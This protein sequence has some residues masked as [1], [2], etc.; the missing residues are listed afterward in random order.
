[1]WTILG[2]EPPKTF[3]WARNKGVK[4]LIANLQK[5]GDFIY[6]EDLVVLRNYIIVSFLFYTIVMARHLLTLMKFGLVAHCWLDFINT[7]SFHGRTFCDQRLRFI[8]YLSVR[9]N[10][11]YEKTFLT[12]N[13]ASSDC[14]DRI[15]WKVW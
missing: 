11:N 9:L 4:H 12:W 6:P 8:T 10:H 3:P 1:M 14:S 5:T 7:T 13:I 15:N 2:W